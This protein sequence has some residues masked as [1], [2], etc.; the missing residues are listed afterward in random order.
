MS[1]KKISELAELTT[2]TTT[3][4]L[5][6]VNAG[7]TKKAQLGNL[8]ISTATQTALDA[9]EATAN[10]STDVVTDQASNT[11]YP[12]VKAVYDWVV[13]LLTGKQDTLVSGTNIKTINSTSLLGSG[14]ISISANPGGSDT[15]VQY[16]S[17]GSFAGSANLTF[18]GTTLDANKLNV[19][20]RVTIEADSTATTQSVAVIESTSTNAG[21][22]LKPNGTGAIMAQVPDGTATGGNARGANSVDLQQ[23]RTINT[24]VASGLRNSILSGID[25]LNSG[26][27]SVIGGGSSNTITQERSFI[28]SGFNNNISGGQSVISGGVNNNVSG[29]YSIIGGGSSNTASS[30]WSTI[31]GGQSNTASTNTHATVVGGSTNTASG[32][33]SVAGGYNN[34]ASNLASVALGSLNTASGQWSFVANNSNAANGQYTSA[35]GANNLASGQCAFAIGLISNAI[36]NNSF[37]SGYYSKTYLYSQQST[38]SGRFSVISD[39]QQSLLTARKLDTLSSAATTVLS[40]DGT[41]TTNLI[42]PDGNNR[43]WNVT[44][45]WV[46][47]VT[48]ITG[49]ATGVSVGDTIMQVDTFGFKRISGTSSMVGSANTLSTNNDTSMATAA[50]GYTAGT[51]QELKLTFTAPTFIG[52]GSVTCRVV[53]KVELTEVA[54]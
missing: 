36:S 34:V 12:S 11:K 17:A 30:S 45:K 43:A 52:G 14:D 23:N 38:A 8:P 33:Y 46:A 28:G 13:G 6:V 27:E 18:D 51:S 41:G 7:S 22:V 32:K 25:N 21:I 16:N 44:V 50:M 47:V 15:Q 35:F 40:L 5:P 31:S 48:S 24:K 26:N 42:I 29:L 19:Q 37:S 39:A 54:Y 10:K 53:A 3:D 4:V 9:K 1:N 2:P 20:E 49:T